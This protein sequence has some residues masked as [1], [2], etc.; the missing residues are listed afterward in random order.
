[1]SGLISSV[2]APGGRELIRQISGTVGVGP[3]PVPAGMTLLGYWDPRRGIYSDTAMTTAANFGDSV[4][5]ATDLSGN[6]NHIYQAT[7][8]KRPLLVAG[9]GGYP[10]FRADGVDD[11]LISLITTTQSQPFTVAGVV[12]IPAAP[13]AAQTLWGATGARV[14]IFP[15][16][17]WNVNASLAGAGGALATGVWQ[18]GIGVFNST[19]SNARAN[20]VSAIV[21]AG[22][23]ILNG[24]QALLATNGTGYMAGDLGPVLFYAGAADTN[25]C[26][27]IE[28]WLKAGYG[29]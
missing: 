11:T 16:R 29:L 27:A 15:N 18:M 19:S 6:G 22:T 5:A 8:T 2:L 10:A 23:N 24:V 13:T 1:M 25:G 26:L 4:A 14:L 21:N 12:S 20:G 3:P 7:S 9:A 17:T 28:A